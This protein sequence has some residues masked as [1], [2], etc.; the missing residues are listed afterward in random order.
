M[1]ITAYILILFSLFGTTPKDNV[2]SPVHTP[3]QELLNNYN[4]DRYMIVEGHFVPPTEGHYAT[5]LKVTRSSHSSIKTDKEYSVSEYGPFG[6]SCEMYEMQA[7]VDPKLIGK[8][9]TRLLIVYKN[10][11]IDGKLVTPIFWE[12]GVN[13]SDNKIVTKKYDYNSD[14][15]QSYQC[16][17]TLDKIWEKIFSGNSTI[18]EWKKLPN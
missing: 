1:K 9:N 15:L 13:A 14:Q 4:Q 11:S 3:F 8:K 6:S 18:L 2:C 10:R 7:N 17:T 5:K 12:A 16:S